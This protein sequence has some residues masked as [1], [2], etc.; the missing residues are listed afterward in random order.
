M[1]GPVFPAGFKAS[2]TNFMKM[3]KNTAQQKHLDHVKSIFASLKS[4][5]IRQ[6]KS[7]MEIAQRMGVDRSAISKMEAGANISIYRTVEF[8]EILGQRIKITDEKGF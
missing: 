5:R 8:A 4:E 2:D 6:G 3:G 7:Q 1:S